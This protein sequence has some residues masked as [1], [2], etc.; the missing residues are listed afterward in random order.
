MN[1]QIPGHTV[2]DLLALADECEEL[3]RQLIECG[4][5]DSA[6]IERSD[7]VRATLAGIATFI[8]SEVRSQAL[9]QNAAQQSP[10]LRAAV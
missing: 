6:L 7:A 4:F 3:D 1:I 2:R 8:A 9:V 10:S 5:S